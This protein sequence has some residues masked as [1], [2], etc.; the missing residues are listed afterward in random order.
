MWSTKNQR[1]DS[2]GSV[3]P[4]DVQTF[5]S[6]TY[7]RSAPPFSTCDSLGI[8]SSKP[9]FYMTK[10]RVLPY[11]VA[12]TKT[13]NGVI[14][15]KINFSQL[16]L[17]DCVCIQLERP[18]KC[19]NTGFSQNGIGTIRNKTKILPCES[20]CAPTASWAAKNTSSCDWLP[21]CQCPNPK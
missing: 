19:F 1:L 2:S 13:P 7:L 20:L 17:H 14:T 4:Y 18:K 3:L 10:K 5:S 9:Q 15:S 11:I 12:C 8:M 21:I 16:F 6:S